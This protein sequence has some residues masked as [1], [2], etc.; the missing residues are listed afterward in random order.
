V[1]PKRPSIES[2]GQQTISS[3]CSS[4]NTLHLHQVM[5]PNTPDSSKLPGNGRGK[6]Q[7]PNHN[8]QTSVKESHHYQESDILESPT[9]YYRSSVADKV[10]DYEDIWGPEM[11]STFKPPI[12][13]VRSSPFSSPE[14]ISISSGGNKKTPD[15]LERVGTPV[16]GSCVSLNSVN[17]N[18]NRLGLVI[19]TGSATNSNTNSPMS[20]EPKS[21]TEDSTAAK[22]GSPFYAEPADALR[23]A[24]V[25]PRRRPRPGGQQLFLHQPRNHRHSDPASF[26]QWPVL[27][28]HT[29]QLE[30]IDSSD[31][32]AATPLSSSV[33]NLAL[34]KNSRN[35][36]TI[37]Q[38][39]V[40]RP[41]GKPVQPPRVRPKNMRGKC[42]NDTS[43]AVDSSWEFIGKLTWCLS[44]ILRVRIEYTYTPKSY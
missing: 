15:L 16:S 7:R 21:Q 22:Q 8:R 2:D 40:N 36:V 39:V 10:S 24:A 43:W 35:G 11:M 5:S 30:R 9:V 19:N 42:F 23:Q 26:Q 37:Q 18:K 12:P 25:V 3:H 34:L 27:P 38:S 14:D 31:E 29:G 1:T 32:L 41:R 17:S 6:K 33:D 20:P 13:M 4:T 28:H 44:E